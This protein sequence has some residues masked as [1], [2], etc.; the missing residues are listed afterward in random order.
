MDPENRKKKRG[1]A[2]LEKTSSSAGK[3]PSVKKPKPQR[4]RKQ[5][6]L[7][8]LYIT[9]TVI[10]ALIVGLFIAWTLFSAAPDTGQFDSTRKPQTTTI[11][12]ENGEEI[13][14]EIPGLSADRKEQFYTFLVAG[15]SGGNTDTLLLG[16]YDVPNQKLSVMSI[17]RDTYV[18]WNGNTVL[19]NSI[20]SRGGGEDGGIQALETVV[21][22]L[23]GVVPDYY[24]LVEWEAV[25]ELVDAIGGVW[26]EVPF[27]M[28]CNDLSQ[29]FK[30][31]LKA[32]YQLLDGDKAMQL[33]RYRINS[34]G[35]TG[36]ID[37]SYGYSNGDLGRIETQQAFLKVALEKCLQPDVL[38][39]KLTE[40][41]RIF[42]ENVETDLT[43]SNMAYFA[44]SA[45]SGL[46]MDNVEFTT[47]PYKAAGQHL[48]PDAE[49]IVAV[50][51]ASFNP[52]EEDIQLSELNVATSAPTSTSTS[53]SSGTSSTAGTA[54]SSAE[55]PSD[56]EVSDDPENT[57]EQTIPETPETTDEADGSGAAGDSGGAE[58]SAASDDPGTAAESEA[59]DAGVGTE[60]QTVPPAPSADEAA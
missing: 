15:I 33:L 53:S 2:R 41:I 17:P 49:E 51:N 4:T 44:K 30:I 57:G 1:G 16:A 40:Y 3:E 38:L 21:G 36:K 25:G 12:D 20:Y 39:P 60:E 22:E 26:F 48:L 54:N 45:V 14:V 8:A 19:I 31:D 18:K 50:I 58:E 52:Y 9:I 34:V 23:T 29:G 6:I 11:V 28:Y 7:R 13:E 42:Q 43:V 35:D 47:L 46:D 56:S 27:D 37:Y 32:G 10:A 24:V 59:P 5:K 55:E